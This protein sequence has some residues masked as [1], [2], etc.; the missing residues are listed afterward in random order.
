[1]DEQTK[2]L[3][4]KN[5]DAF[6]RSVEAYMNWGLTPEEIASNQAEDEAYFAQ[7]R[8]EFAAEDQATRE[9]DADERIYQ[10]QRARDRAFS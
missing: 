1:M 10:R 7:R 3:A 6:H 5:R 9:A 2:A 4:R 8:A